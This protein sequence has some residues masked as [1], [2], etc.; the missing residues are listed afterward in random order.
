M[1]GKTMYQVNIVMILVRE[2]IF[3]NR[4]FNCPTTGHWLAISKAEAKKKKK[5]VLLS[6]FQMKRLNRPNKCGNQIARS[7]TTMHVKVRPSTINWLY[8]N[9]EPASKDTP[10]RLECD[11]SYLQWHWYYRLGFF[12]VLLVCKIWYIAYKPLCRGIK[13]TVYFFVF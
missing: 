9:S 7:S 13:R 8:F 5:K 4:W 3:K 2:A 10:K 11:L 12:R 1:S 6:N